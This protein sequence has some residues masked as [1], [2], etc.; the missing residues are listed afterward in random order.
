MLGRN[1]FRIGRRVWSA[2]KDRDAIAA[3]VRDP[4]KSRTYYPEHPRK[5]K[6]AILADLVQWRVRFDEINQYYYLYGLDRRDVDGNGVMPYSLFRAMRNAK[7]LRPAGLSDYYGTSYNYVC[8]LRDKFLFSQLA[9]SLGLPAGRPRAICTRDSLF[10]IRTGERLPLEHLLSDPSLEM[11]G[12]AKPVDGI[13]GADIF[14]LRIEGGALFIDGAEATID[15]LKRKFSRRYLLEPRLAQNPAMAKLHPASIN[16]VRLVTF[17]RSGAVELFTAAQRIGSGGSATDNFSAGGILVRI[18][19][20]TGVLRGDG[21]MKP[22]FGGRV[23][24]HPDTGVVF[25][26]FA[27]AEFDRAVALACKFH[28]Y[29]PGVHSIG[30]DIA[31]TPDGPV[32]IEANDDWDGAVPMTLEPDFRQR[33]EAMF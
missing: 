20:E 25:D 33:F 29:L 6:L 4:E 21:Y 19:R 9:A 5:S 16:T 26:G 27:V 22:S 32:F 11:D 7:N 1:P 13:M 12:I 24:R 14:P 18:D 10:L 17:N 23:D 28:D 30:W 2:L 8:V 15:G 3:M 31:I